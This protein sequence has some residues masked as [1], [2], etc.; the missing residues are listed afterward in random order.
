MKELVR[1]DKNTERQ[2]IIKYLKEFSEEKTYVNAMWLEGA[3]GVGRVDEYSDIDFWFDVGAGF[4]ESFLYECIAAAEKLGELDSRYD[5]IRKEIA[6][7]N[8]HLKNAPEYLTLDI[9]VQSHEIRGKE[10]TCYVK[11]DI[12]ERPLIIFDKEEIISFCDYKEDKKEIRRIFE[13]N[14][15][16]IMQA[17][18]VTKYIKRGLYPEAY[19]KYMENIAEPLVTIARL[20]YTPRLYDYGLCHISEHLP[21]DTVGELEDLFKVADLRDIEEKLKKA[22]SLLEKYGK[23]LGYHGV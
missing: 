11:D 3:D 9:C 7:S 10:A 14:E 17:G 6:Q 2:D 21:A 15:N 13:E 1:E 4:Q 16:R 23:E 8:I 22:F 12:A 18:R 20:I 19:M 5:M